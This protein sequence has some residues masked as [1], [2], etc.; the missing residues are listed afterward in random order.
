MKNFL[1]ETQITELKKDWVVKPKGSYITLYKDEVKP[2]HWAQYARILG[3]DTDL[4]SVKVLTF[5]FY[6]PK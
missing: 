3:F 4:P 5:G 1:T 2:E 6:Q